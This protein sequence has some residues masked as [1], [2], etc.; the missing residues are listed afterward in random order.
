MSLT[1]IVSIIENKGYSAVVN[2]VDTVLNADRKRSF[3][4]VLAILYLNEIVFCLFR[5][6]RCSGK[7]SD[8]LN[9]VSSGIKP[10]AKGL[11]SCRH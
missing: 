8:F 2:I 9:R 6:I 4:T 1:L 11:G 7:N 5:P 3:D 10:F